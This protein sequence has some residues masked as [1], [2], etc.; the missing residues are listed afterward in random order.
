MVV[1]SAERKTADRTL[2]IIIFMQSFVNEILSV[3]VSHF[4]E[5]AEKLPIFVARIYRIILDSTRNVC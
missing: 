4:I 5:T 2:Y 3:I 1:P